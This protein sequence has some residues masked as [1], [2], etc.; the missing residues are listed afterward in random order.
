MTWIR[1][2]SHVHSDWSYDGKWSLTRLAG[3]FSR[4]GYRVVLVTEHDQGFDEARRLEH[5]AACC[6]ANLPNLLLV[7]GI[8]YSDASNTIHLLVWG[9]VPFIGSKSEPERV[10]SAAADFGGVVVFAHPSRREAWKRFEPR[11]KDKL[12]GIEFWNRKTDGWAPS[13]RAWPLL[14]ASGCVPFAGLDFHQ[15]SQ[16]FPMSTLLETGSVIDEKT[17]LSAL[18]GRRCKPKV[19]GLNADAFSEGLAGMAARR[20]EAFRSLAAVCYRKVVPR[21]T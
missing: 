18:R 19:F 21:R 6:E 4:R 17:V 3:A 9:D 15:R 8:E 14:N 2:A 7:P 13:K 5:R 20:L 10:L 12:L 1:A 11:W 16:F